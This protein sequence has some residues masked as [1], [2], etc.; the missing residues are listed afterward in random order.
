MYS[1]RKINI[2]NLSSSPPSGTVFIIGIP[3]V[4]PSNGSTHGYFCLA[5]SR[6]QALA[7]TTGTNCTLFSPSGLF[8]IDR[9]YTLFHSHIFAPILTCADAATVALWGAMSAD[10]QF[11]AESPSLPPPLPPPAAP[12]RKSGSLKKLIIVACCAAAAVV[13]II[14]LGVIGISGNCCGTKVDVARIFVNSSIEIPLKTYRLQVGDYPSTAEGLQALITAPA[15]KAD[16]WR[17]PYVYFNNKNQKN[18][19]F[20]DPWGNP[21]QYRYPGIHNR[22]GYDVWS[23]GPDGRDGTADDIGNWNTSMPDL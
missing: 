16:R 3:W 12:P 21:Y 20:T 11:H 18:K 19:I 17:G 6:H 15:G 22:S 23:K 5:A 14:A 7:T 4:T 10:E 8:A 13:A 9:N 2:D 1:D